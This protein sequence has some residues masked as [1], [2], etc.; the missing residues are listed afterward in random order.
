MQPVTFAQRSSNDWT[1][2]K[3]ESLLCGFRPVCV[4]YGARNALTHARSPSAPFLY[5]ATG[6]VF[7]LAF[8]F[9]CQI[10]RRKAIKR[11]RAQGASAGRLWW[12]AFK[13]M[14]MTFCRGRRTLCLILPAFINTVVG[15]K[16]P[17]T[18]LRSLFIVIF[19]GAALK[20]LVSLW[21]VAC[22]LIQEGVVQN[23]KF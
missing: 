21:V 17:A 18:L 2:W 14:K 20:R 4:R 23:T 16:H 10:K 22:W 19:F 3:I 9:Y 15:G 7:A 1:W 11:R 13:L 12:L 5:S 6:R 8:C